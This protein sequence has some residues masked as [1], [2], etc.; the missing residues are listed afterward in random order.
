MYTSYGH[1]G[2]MLCKAMGF[3]E[4]QGT[5]LCS[6]MSDALIKHKRVLVTRQCKSCRCDMQH[7]LSLGPVTLRMVK[8]APDQN[9]QATQAV[10]YGSCPFS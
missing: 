5:L 8:T 7:A 3:V 6:K 10:A 2:V 9:R 4:V 1:A